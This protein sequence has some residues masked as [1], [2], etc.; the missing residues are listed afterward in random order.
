MNRQQK[1][2][3]GIGV[4]LAALGAGAAVAWRR[5]M[6][7]GNTGLGYVKS[8]TRKRGMVLE[9]HYDPIMP[10][11]KRVSYAQK[12]VEAGVHDPEMMHLARAITGNRDQDVQIGTQTLRVKGARCAD[13]D[14]NCEIKAIGDWVKHNVRYTGDVAPIVMSDG[15]YEA[16]DFFSAGKRSAEMGGEDC[17]G[18]SIL[19]A[20]LLTLN[21]IT[22]MFRITAP[23][24]STEWGHIYTLAG[25][26][27]E[28]PTKY[29]A[30]DTTLPNYRV[31]LEA[32]YGRNKD[33]RA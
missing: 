33:F 3:V 31:G 6:L 19:N 1:V 14:V 12:L 15:R 24:G 32:P 7:S 23:K 5:G 8:R 21:G 16:I 27:K 4:G 10:I 11:G 28:N 29:V 22:S 18:H 9:E 26:P 20:T 17:D 13:R 30:V 25:L 2:I